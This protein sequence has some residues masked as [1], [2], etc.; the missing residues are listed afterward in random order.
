M[1]IFEEEKPVVG[2]VIQ[3]FSTVIATTILEAILNISNHSNM[4][5]FMMINPGFVLINYNS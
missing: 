1:L 4:K 3:I 2:D 5:Y